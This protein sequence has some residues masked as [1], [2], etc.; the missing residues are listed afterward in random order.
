MTINWSQVDNNTAAGKGGTASGGGIV[1]VDI[2]ALTGAT[3][4]GVLTI[5]YSVVEGN[6]AGGLGGGILNGLPSPKIPIGGTLTLNHSQV[7]AN[8]AVLGGGG[9]LVQSRRVP[10]HDLALERIP[11]APPAQ[12]TV[13]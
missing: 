4:S 2:S 9:I 11:D 6:S 12:A 13:T 5:N 10:L 7:T 1:N 8:S 3:T